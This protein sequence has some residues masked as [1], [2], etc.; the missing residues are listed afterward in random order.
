MRCSICDR[1]NSRWIYHNYH[2]S[3]CEEVITQTIGNLREKDMDKILD[4]GVEMENW[5]DD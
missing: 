3:K 5:T 2:C 4:P 1:K